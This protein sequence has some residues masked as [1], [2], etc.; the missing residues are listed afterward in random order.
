MNNNIDYVCLS[1]E[2]YKNLVENNLK[3][4]YEIKKL[5]EDCKKINEQFNYYEQL[6]IEEIYE[7]N[8]H[9]IKNIEFENNQINEIS[10]YYRQLSAEFKKHGLVDKNKI[11]EN[12][13]RLY[14][15][16]QETLKKEEEK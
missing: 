16:Y 11:F 12:I 7:N 14:E 6:V 5:K 10:Y 1:L 15:M 8:K 2:K 9:L 3:Q 4:Q 13:N